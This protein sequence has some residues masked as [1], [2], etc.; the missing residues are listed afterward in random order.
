MNNDTKQLEDSIAIVRQSLNEVAAILKRNGV[1]D[2]VTQNTIFSLGTDDMRSL[3]AN[4][5][6]IKFEMQKLEACYR[7]LPPLDLFK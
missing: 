3:N 7:I 4:M 2:E 1:I 5:S 6:F